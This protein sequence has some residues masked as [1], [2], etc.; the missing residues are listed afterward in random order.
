MGQEALRFEEFCQH[1][2]LKEFSKE[3]V[4]R[5]ILYEHRGAIA[6]EVYNDGTKAHHVRRCFGVRQRGAV[7]LFW[8]LPPA[9]VE[10]HIL[11]L[12]IV[13]CLCIVEW[14]CGIDGL[15]FWL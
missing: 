14:R 7:K 11:G 1:L 6:P 4:E 13:A 10:N 9:L 12:I 15:G 5:H 8:S 2:D 3:A